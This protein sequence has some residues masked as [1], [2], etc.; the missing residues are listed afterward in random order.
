V[1]HYDLVADVLPVIY[2]IPEF[3]RVAVPAAVAGV[4]GAVGPITF[5]FPRTREITGFLILP[6]DGT[7]LSLA[8]L[9]LQI[10]DQFE[11]EVF[12]DLVGS[13]TQGRHPFEADGM[14]MAGRGFRPFPMQRLVQ[15][16]DRWLFT[17]RNQT[18]G[19]ITAASVSIHHRAFR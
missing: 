10:V 2:S 19:I 13:S 6:Q 7:T 18:A 12:S 16:G 1:P 17:L 3:R 14:M 15:G 9:S 4:S 11:E 5:R 8:G